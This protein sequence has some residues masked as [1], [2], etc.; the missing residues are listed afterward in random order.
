VLLRVPSSFDAA[1]VTRL[2]EILG[3]AG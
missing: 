3:H 2:L 1:A